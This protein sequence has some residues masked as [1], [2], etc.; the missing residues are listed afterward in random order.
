[1][2]WKAYRQAPRAVSTGGGGEE[3]SLERAMRL[4]HELLGVLQ[5]CG[6]MTA[7]ATAGTTSRASPFA[8]DNESRA[9][10]RP[11]G[12]S[13]DS[14]NAPLGSY[15]KRQGPTTRPMPSRLASASSLPMCAPA[16]ATHP[17]SHG[18]TK[19]REEEAGSHHPWPG[20]S[21]AGSVS[22]PGELD[23][24]VDSDEWRRA[25][26]VVGPT[27]SDRASSRVTENSLGA[28]NS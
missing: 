19:R 11:G 13:E 14:F 7:A 16:G 5:D 24:F 6:G 3:T 15:E 27:L 23:P 2:G 1:R 25:R 9:R 17:R 20:N 28:D 12:A 26:P 10:P 8:E 21:N 4:R 18:K 22:A